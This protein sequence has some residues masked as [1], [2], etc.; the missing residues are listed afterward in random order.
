HAG[1]PQG[2]THEAPAEAPPADSSALMTD[3][4]AMSTL[5]ADWRSAIGEPYT[6]P[7]IDIPFAAP[8]TLD[9]RIPVS[10]PGRGRPPMGGDPETAIKEAQTGYAQ[11]AAG[12]RRLQQDA[13]SQTNQIIRALDQCGQDALR[14]ID[15]SMMGPLS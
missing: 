12:A 7:F 9:L 5:L 8:D 13:L 2:T 1:G 4:Q 14:Q 10:P 11:F 3:S 6:A 15:D